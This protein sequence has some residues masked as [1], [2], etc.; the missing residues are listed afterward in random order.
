MDIVEMPY[1]VKT[2]LG[3]RGA[4]QN[5]K[6]KKTLNMTTARLNDTTVSVHVAHGTPSTKVF[7]FIME[8][9]GQI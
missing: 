5:F 3:Y 1:S 4:I 7:I 2:T 8:E 9:N 6:E